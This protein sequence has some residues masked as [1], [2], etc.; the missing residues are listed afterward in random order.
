MSDNMLVVL[1]VLV[2]VVSNI[3]SSWVSYDQGL[4][5]GAQ[6]QLRYIQ[7]LAYKEASRQVCED[8]YGIKL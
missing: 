1:L 4:R 3:T 8:L 6:A 5:N 2:L 7:C